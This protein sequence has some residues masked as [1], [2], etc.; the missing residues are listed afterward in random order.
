MRIRFVKALRWF[1]IL[2][3]AAGV[4]AGIAAGVARYRTPPQEPVPELKTTRAIPENVRWGQFLAGFWAQRNQDFAKMADYYA[5]VLE[6]DPDN[7]ELQREVYFIKAVEGRLDMRPLIE[8][9]R[10]QKK[11]EYL[12]D[13]ALFALDFRAGKYDDALA[14]LRGKPPHVLNA[15]LDD[16]LAAWACAGLGDKQKALDALERARDKKDLR[17]MYWY[18]R[19]LISWYFKDTARADAAF[20]EMIA[21]GTPNLSAWIYMR[22]FYEAPRDRTWWLAQLLNLRTAQPAVLRLL[23]Q[24]PPMP[25]TDAAQGAAEVFFNVSASL[26]AAEKTAEV[27]LILNGLALHLNPAAVVPKIWGAELME[28]LKMYGKANAIYRSIPNPPDVVAFKQALNL[29]LMDAYAESESILS[30]LAV[31]EPDNPTLL[32]LLADAYNANGRHD[33]ALNTYGKVIRLTSGNADSVKELCNAHF[34]RGL[35]YES[36]REWRLAESDLE[37]AVRLCPD[38][39]FMLNY[40]GYSWVDRGEKMESAVPLLQRA[41]ELDADNPAII[42][43]LAWSHYRRRDYEKALESAEKALDMM[44][45][46][47]VINA[48]LGDIYRALGR[49]REARF[50]YKK[51]L[52][53]DTDLTASLKKQLQEKLK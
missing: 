12:A 26:G 15:V 50:Q 33:L 41:A 28:A 44:P 13:Y 53:L 47:S 22:S 40:L 2:L 8:R 45:G 37:Q 25:L 18:H 39:A 31:V 36:R 48:H 1:L 52:D 35:L 4:A 5:Q 29:H 19:A 34:Y 16:F 46:S 43:S 42:D 7:P 23:N 11:P 32:T 10:L 20:K 14:A 30:R 49:E 3:A 17:Q 21:L 24:M 9:M 6:D 38:D 27:S 51:A